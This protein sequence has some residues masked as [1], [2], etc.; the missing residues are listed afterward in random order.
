VKVIVIGAGLAGLRA[1]GLASEYG[2]DVTVLEASQRVGGRAD[3]DLVDGFW[4]DRG[5]QLI[6]PGYSEARRALNLQDLDRGATQ[7]RTDR[8][9]KKILIE[10][11]ITSP[12]SSSAWRSSEPRFLTPI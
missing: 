10:I 5:F 8:S 9:P 3:T 12:A 11:A 4:C 2:H 1:A 7:E 6:N